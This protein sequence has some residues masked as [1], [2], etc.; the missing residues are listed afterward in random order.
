MSFG[1]Q[2]YDALGNPLLDPQGRYTRL[3]YEA[4]V[5]SSGSVNLPE[6]SGKQ[7]VQFG[8]RVFLYNESEHYSVAANVTRSGTTV[9]WIL[10]D[11]TRTIIS[12]FAYT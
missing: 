3:V 6:L 4:E 10:A 2:I 8:E 5:T 7:S 1:I 12:V 11:N 9:S